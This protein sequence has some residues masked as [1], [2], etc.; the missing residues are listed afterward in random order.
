MQELN[1]IQNK[2]RDVVKR[3]KHINGL[4][5]F[6]VFISA[7]CVVF[8]A[9]VLLE[10]AG[11]FD[12]GFRTVLFWLM[13]GFVLFTFGLYVAF[14]FVKDFLYYKNP[15]YVKIAK[16]VGAHFPAIKDELANT[17]QLMNESNRNYSNQL[18]EAAFKNV[19]NK[20]EKLDFNQAVDFYIA[21]KFIRI[22]SI[23]FLFTAV[24]IALVPSFSSASY[25]LIN[26]N[27]NFTPPPKFVFE[28]QPGNA[29]ITKGDNITIRIKTIGEKPTAIFLS[30]KSEDQTEFTEKKIFPDSPGIFVFETAAVKNSFEYFAS[31]EKITSGVYKISVVNRPII[32]GFEIIVT[33]PAYSHLPER[34]QKDNGNIA[35]LPGSKIKL[36]LNSSRELS[37]AALIFSD[38]TAKQ[39]NITF[40][41]ASAEF[42]VSKETNYQMQITDIQNLTNA[43]PIVYSIKT[44]S[45]EA[46]AIEMISPTENIKLGN[47]NKISLVAK[48]A[49]DYGFSKMNL[50]YRLS[51]SKYRK[52]I[53]EF[54]Q[55]PITVSSQLKEDE[56]YFIWDLAPLV[57]AEGEVLSYYLE[58]FDNDNVNGPK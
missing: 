37:K 49:D 7:A 58:V 51:A 47:E 50:N 4:K 10:A 40:T 18:V 6:F 28:I 32:T 2:L 5:R 44:L 17:V 38:T 57:L 46:P 15:D 22:G 9:I 30:T 55:I 41:K 52:A 27:K 11:N 23:V 8:L 56:V 20:T 1:K 31:A 43:Y 48:I 53:E 36:M 54:T 25:R 12:S 26:F 3:D 16:K 39:M 24:L 21:K 45:D 42:A 33:P 13:I 29:E 19:Y 14:T 35:A 34:T